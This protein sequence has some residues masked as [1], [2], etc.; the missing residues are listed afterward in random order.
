MDSVV[1]NA[2]P[3]SN[4]GKAQITS[5]TRDSTESIQPR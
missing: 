1:P 3:S 2:M 4:T 5:I